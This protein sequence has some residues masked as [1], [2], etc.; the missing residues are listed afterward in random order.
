MSLLDLMT[1]AE[2]V[3]SMEYNEL[4]EKIINSGKV[5]SEEYSIEDRN[6]I[7]NFIG[8]FENLKNNLDKELK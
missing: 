7:V 4:M 8:T 2:L 6:N 3:G 5:V 1:L